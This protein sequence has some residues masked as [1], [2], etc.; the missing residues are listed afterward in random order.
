LLLAAC[1]GPP[2]T[3]DSSPW[4]SGRL[5]LRVEAHGEL[6]AQSLNAAFDLQGDGNRGELRLAT[7][8]GTR[9]L[10]A[11]WAPGR[12]DLATPAGERSYGSLDELSRQAL[13]ESVPLA[14]LPDWLAG[15]GWPGAP[16]RATDE[17]FEQ[18]GWRVLL[19]RRSEGW[20]E[21]RRDAAPALVLKVRLEGAE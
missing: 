13:G 20:I 12:A 16:H 3:P 4:T 1:A 21:A 18:L 11:R 7:P 19:A 15:R 10:T 6:A 8:L 2:Q 9:L 14:A 17:G 5:S